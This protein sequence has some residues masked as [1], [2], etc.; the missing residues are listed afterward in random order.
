MEKDMRWSER[1]EVIF[2]YSQGNS[3]VS[4]KL[5]GPPKGLLVEL[6]RLLREPLSLHI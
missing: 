3:I 2:F 4:S 6:H 5:G 1:S